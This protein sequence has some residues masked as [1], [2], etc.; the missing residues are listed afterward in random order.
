MP[1]GENLGSKLCVGCS[2]VSKDRKTVA[3]GL[4]DFKMKARYA[5]CI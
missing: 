4:G 5:G 2:G 3:Y 1:G